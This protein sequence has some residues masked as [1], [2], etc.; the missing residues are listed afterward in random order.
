M[1][2]NIN[3]KQNAYD[4]KLEIDEQQEQHHSDDLHGNFFNFIHFDSNTCSKLLWK[5]SL[6]FIL[7]FMYYYVILN[8]II[9]T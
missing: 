2:C 7:I 9:C 8:S 3:N 4:D 6:I 5:I 1:S